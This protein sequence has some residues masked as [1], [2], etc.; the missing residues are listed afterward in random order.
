MSGL[1]DRTGNYGFAFFTR[2]HL[3]DTAIPEW[4]A[5]PG[6]ERFL[7]D[8]LKIQ[9]DDIVR[10]FEHWGVLQGRSKSYRLYYRAKL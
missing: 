4:I 9:P 5:T 6:V 1:A 3:D 2:G 8:I 10:A 7:V